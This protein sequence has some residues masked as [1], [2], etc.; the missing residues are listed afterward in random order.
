MEEVCEFLSCVLWREELVEDSVAVETLTYIEDDNEEPVILP[1]M[2]IPL[3][4]P[5]DTDSSGWDT[6]GSESDR[7]AAS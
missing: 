5:A 6:A 7:S 3:A 2:H 1:E 4:T